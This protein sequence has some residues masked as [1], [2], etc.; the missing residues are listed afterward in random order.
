MMIFTVATSSIRRAVVETIPDRLVYENSG[1]YLYI[2]IKTINNPDE[3]SLSADGFWFYFRTKER[4]QGRDARQKFT[5][6]ANDDGKFEVF[7][8][9]LGNELIEKRLFDKPG[10]EI[11]TENDLF[12]IKINENLIKYKNC[13]TSIDLYNNTT[14]EWEYYSGY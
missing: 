10:F 4:K 3:Y 11:F 14:G 12:I 8:L 6:T 2:K 1:G 13:Y 5:N 7:V 9:G